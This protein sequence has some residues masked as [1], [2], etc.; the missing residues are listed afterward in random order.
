MKTLL[1]VGMACAVAATVFVGLDASTVGAQPAAAGC[2]SVITEDTRL[3]R[4]LKD[5]TN[6]LELAGT[7]ITLDLDGHTISGIGVPDWY[8]P[9]RPGHDD[10]ERGD[11]ELRRRC[12]Q[13]FRRRVPF[14]VSEGAR[15]RDW[16]VDVLILRRPVDH[17][18]KRDQS[19]YDIWG[20]FLP[21]LPVDDRQQHPWKRLL[22]YLLS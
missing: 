1:R 18:R 9:H 19:Q 4:N 5:C 14:A 8:Q 16:G 2:G 17:R 21:R 20:R 6:G 7:G 11:L 22:R 15:E 3:T 10:K 12:Q 13:R